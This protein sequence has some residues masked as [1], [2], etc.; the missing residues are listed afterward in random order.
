M[1]IVNN[2]STDSGQINYAMAPVLGYQKL[3]EEGTK[4][5]HESDFSPSYAIVFTS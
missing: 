5:K 4:A 3:R 2:R 1:H